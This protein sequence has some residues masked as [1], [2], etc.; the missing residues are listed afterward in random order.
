[1]KRLSQLVS[2]DTNQFGPG[3]DLIVAILG[4]LLVMNYVMSY[5]YSQEKDANQG[6]NF[7]LASVSFSAGDFHA[8]PVTK[9]VDVDK[10]NKK[11][12]LIVQEY[13]RIRLEFPYIF[14]IG[15][16]SQRD[17]PSAEDK[18]ES[19][20]MQR[21]WMYAGRRAALIAAFLQQ[22]LEPAQRDNLVVVTTGE[23]D[24]REQSNPMSQGNAWV[25]IMFGK[26][27]KR[28]VQDNTAGTAVN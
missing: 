25:E 21:N 26:E 28:P 18:S 11:L 4:M 17:D 22:Q 5:L 24:L 20:R 6:G 8:R 3:T 1:M 13:D 9:L 19:G 14:V 27:W 10:T 16:S 23:F 15:H 2:E 7:R 12:R